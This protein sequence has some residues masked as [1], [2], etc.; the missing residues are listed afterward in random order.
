MIALDFEVLFS[1]SISNYYGC[2]I[3]KKGSFDIIAKFKVIH[4][5]YPITDITLESLWPRNQ[6][7]MI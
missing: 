6:L 4:G 1:E 5:L 3:M 2:C 7:P